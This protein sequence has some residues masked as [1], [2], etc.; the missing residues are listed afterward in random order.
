MD[1]RVIEKD[2]LYLIENRVFKIEI[3]DQS[4]ITHW[5]I[6]PKNS[7]IIEKVSFEDKINNKNLTPQ[8]SWTTSTSITF[9]FETDFGMLK[10]VYSINNIALIM[11]IYLISHKETEVEYATN[12]NIKHDAI[13]LFMVGH[14]EFDIKKQQTTEANDLLLIK[15]NLDIYLGFIFKE[16]A[17]LTMNPDNCLEFSFKTKVKLLTNDMFMISYTSSLV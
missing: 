16:K 9:D 4:N 1:A 17:I 3:T 5:S 10:K 2:G 14:N 8:H 11:D 15:K 6:K 13:D 12:L 7:E